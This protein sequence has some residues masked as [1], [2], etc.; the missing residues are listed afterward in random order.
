MICRRAEGNLEVTAFW[1]EKGVRLGDGRLA[2]L[3]AELS[4]MARF[5]GMEQV[6]FADGWRRAPAVQA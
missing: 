3:E 1:P 5:T 4:R 2:R 6:R